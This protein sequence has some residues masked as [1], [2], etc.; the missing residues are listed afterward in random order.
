MQGELVRSDL[1]QAAK[2]LIAK[3]DN[4]TSQEQKHRELNIEL[5]SQRPTTCWMSANIPL[6]DFD[7]PN[8]F[9]GDESECLKCIQ[10]RE[11]GKETM[12]F[13]FTDMKRIQVFRGQV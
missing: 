10:R 1:P 6:A 3:M 7:E 4:G 9:P 8:N 5:N 11:Q 2:E 12:C 13:H